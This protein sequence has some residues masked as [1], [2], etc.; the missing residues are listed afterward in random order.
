MA[1]AGWLGPKDRWPLGAVLYLSR[2]RVT[3]QW[4][5]HDGKTINIVVGVSIV[6][7]FIKQLTTVSG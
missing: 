7:N 4:L 1:Q 5:C 3:S 2:K 6:I